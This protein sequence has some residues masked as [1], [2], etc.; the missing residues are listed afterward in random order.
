M[1]DRYVAADLHAIGA[2]LLDQR[3]AGGGRQAGDVQPRAGDLG[4]LEVGVQR[5]RFGGNRNAGEAHARGHLAV[6]GVAATAEEGGDGLQPDAEVEGG[7]VLQRAHQHGVVDDGHVG[8][9][10]GH[11]ARFDQLGH[12]RQAL[13]LEAQGERAHRVDVGA[14]ELLGA[15]GEHLHQA[16]FVQRWVGVGRNGQAGDAAG[17]RRFHL[18]L[19]RGAVFEAGFAQA[20]GEI[21]EAG[22]DHQAAGVDGAFGVETVGGAAQRDDLALGDIDVV[23]D[24]AAPGRVDDATVGNEDVHG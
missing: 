16:G 8:L 11:A 15:V 23:H 10:E 7:G 14:I 5:D 12:L 20:R 21:D 22:G 3:E 24:V 6:V 19:E 2:R 18:G 1:V 17:H 13:A 4:K 9:G